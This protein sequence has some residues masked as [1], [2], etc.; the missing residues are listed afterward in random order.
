MKTVFPGEELVAPGVLRNP[1]LVEALYDPEASR[2]AALRNLLQ[3]EGYENLEAV[4]NEGREEG[5]E[6]GQRRA[7]RKLLSVRGLVLRSADVAAIAQCVS[8]K[9]FEQWIERAA[10]AQRIEDVFGE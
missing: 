5:R 9:A 1:V 2:R 4:R 7:L 6:E 3:R 10:T 8:D